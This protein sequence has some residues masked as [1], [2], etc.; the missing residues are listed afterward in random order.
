[1][2][3]ARMHKGNYG[4]IKAFFDILTKEGFTIKGFKI[5]EGKDGLFVGLP[6][7]KDKE[8]EYQNTIYME[9]DKKDQLNKYCVNFYNENKPDSFNDLNDDPVTKDINDLF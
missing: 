8:G 6:S 9:K 2:K 7:Y 3:I 1:M 5:I 4:K